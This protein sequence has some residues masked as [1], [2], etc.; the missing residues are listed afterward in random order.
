MSLI[1]TGHAAAYADRVAAWWVLAK[2]ALGS[3]SEAVPLVP[4]GRN[5]A[6]NLQTD[7][8][9]FVDF[10]QIT[11]LAASANDFLNRTTVEYVFLQSR[12]VLAAL[13]DHCRRRG[14]SVNS[15]ILDL[16]GYL[17]YYNGLTP[18]S[19]LLHPAVLE[20]W[21]LLLN[22]NALPAAGVMAPAISPLADATAYPNGY[23]TRAVGG[24]ATLGVTLPSTYCGSRLA[25]V[26]TADFVGGSAPPTVT[27]TGTDHLGNAGA[28]WTG[29]LSGNN[30]A[31]ILSGTGAIVGAVTGQ[32]RATVTVTS[33][34]GIAVGSILVV[35][36]GL[37]DQE[38]VYVEAVP[39]GTTFTAVFNKSHSAG[40]TVSGR[41]TLLLTPGV[42]GRRC[43]SVSALAIGVTAHTSGTLRI[44]GV[45]D[46]SP[47]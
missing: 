28:A 41:T 39:S 11:D 27:V 22:V 24:S 16:P 35:N 47:V 20:P 33:T 19:C 4:S 10:E 21:A 36:A 6:A 42:A 44:D 23:A 40:A 38:T 45:L 18:F 30:P 7:V 1:S 37:P 31:S 13:N 32:T 8:L 12:N 9:G 25:A 34:A 29:T 26:V 14:A 46:R 15:L 17:S 5:V 43:V 3:R 2:A